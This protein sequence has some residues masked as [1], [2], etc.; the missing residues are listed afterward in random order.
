M[1][2]A[3]RQFDDGDVRAGGL[4]N[5]VRCRHA[6]G[7]ERSRPRALLAD[8]DLMQCP[9]W[10]RLAVGGTR[11]Q[12]I[13]LIVTATPP[14]SRMKR[15]S[16]SESR[17]SR[18]AVPR[19]RGLQSGIQLRPRLRARRC[20]DRDRH[21][22]PR[23][24]CWLGLH[25]DLPTECFHNP[26]RQ[27]ESQASA[28]AGSCRISSEERIE[29]PPQIVW[30][31]T[32]PAIGHRHRERV[33]RSLDTEPNSSVGGGVANGIRQQ[34]LEHPGH[35]RGAGCVIG[36]PQIGDKV[37]AF[38]RAAGWMLAIAL[39]TISSRRSR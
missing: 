38:S 6:E 21:R 25:A 19:N 26:L 33:T 9:P 7:D 35:P 30:C 36:A 39:S 16:Q 1:D 22:E 18:R 5:G 20:H 10:E 3:R 14:R 32:H 12:L 29:D 17:G 34:V 37:Q 31:D 15:T 4:S 23:T 28:R 2:D 11:S 27:R 8:S 24:F 13:K